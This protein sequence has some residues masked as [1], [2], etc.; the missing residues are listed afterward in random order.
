MIHHQ[1]IETL[2]QCGDQLIRKR[3]QR[4]PFPPNSLHARV[5]L[6]PT[7]GGGLH[8]AKTMNLVP[9][10]PRSKVFMPNLA[11]FRQRA[12]RDECKLQPYPHSGAM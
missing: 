5:Q 7:P 10:W 11:N 9:G 6:R 4:G 8:R 2:C 3:L 12:E 1:Q